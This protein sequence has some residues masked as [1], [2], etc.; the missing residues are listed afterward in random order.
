[1]LFGALLYTKSWISAPLA[2]ES[3][4]SDLQLWVDLGKFERIDPQ[5]GKTAKSVLER[6]LWYLSDETVGLALFS[7]QVVVEDKE[8]LV[9]ALSKEPGEQKVR[10]DPVILNEGAVFGDFAT[11]RT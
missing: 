7:E 10:G 9:C 2:A 5:I 8:K 3:P 6:H 1:M 4:G 11:T